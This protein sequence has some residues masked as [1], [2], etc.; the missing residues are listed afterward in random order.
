MAT[1]EQRVGGASSRLLMARDT[2]VRGIEIVVGMIVFL[3]LLQIVLR[4][5]LF[6]T[7]LWLDPEVDYLDAF[8]RGIRG[9]L[10]Y[11][12]IIIPVSLLIGFL[13]G[14][15][16]V[17][18]LRTLRWPVSVY[19]D[20]FRGVPPLVIVIFAFLFGSA[21]LPSRVGGRDAAL[22]VAAI[23]LA[24]H[25]GAYQAEIFRA[26]FQSVAQGQLEAA[27]ALGMRPTQAMQYVVLPQALRL[28]LPPLGNETAVLIKD[29]SLLA[30]IGATDLFGLSQEFSQVIIFT[31]GSQLVWY[32]A[33][34][35][36]VALVYFVMTFAVTRILFLLERKLHVKGLE[37]I[38]I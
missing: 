37:A 32:F 19:V 3:V 16:R 33:I 25:S 2:T 23:A 20:F 14:W 22:V 26:G 17:S 8:L 31:P 11:L 30:A 13:F 24:M 18:R 12:A 1:A 15:A 9:T 35:T 38:S 36:A 34:W 10:G 5:E 28:S 27:Q 29:S 4:F 6:N 7:R 21:L